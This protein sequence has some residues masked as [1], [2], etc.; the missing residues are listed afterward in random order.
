MRQHG[1]IE[2]GWKFAWG[3]GKQRLGTAEVRRYR[4]GRVV[5]TLRFSE[6]MVRL[7]SIE[8]VRDIVL[9]EIAHALAGLDQGHNARWKAVCKRI[10]AKPQ[11]FAGAEVQT[12]APRY[13]LHCDHCQQHLGERHRRIAPDRLAQA[14]CAS[15]GPVSK[16]K[17]R[18]VQ[19]RPAK[20]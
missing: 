5:K 19:A 11:R 2:A 9:H 13:T 10:G 18:L 3:R 8:E 6:H 15:C 20:G 12:P 1:L 14:Y 7:N 16:G 17:L 4:D